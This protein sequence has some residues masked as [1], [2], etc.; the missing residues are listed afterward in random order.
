[1]SVRE[2]GCSYTAG[3]HNTRHQVAMMTKFCMMV[4]HTRGSSVWN[5]VFHF[6]QYSFEVV[7]DFWKIYA[8][9]LY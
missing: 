2:C 1:M 9:L 8:P 5:F 4:S 7:E 3:V 6:W